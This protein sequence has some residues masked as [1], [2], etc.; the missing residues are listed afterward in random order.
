M[1]LIAIDECHCVS[2]WGHD[3]RPSYS[4]LAKLRDIFPGVPILGLTATATTI[5]AQ[6]IAVNLG[7][8]DPAHFRASFDRKNLYLEVRR[9]ENDDFRA[10]FTPLLTRNLEADSVIAKYTFE[11]STI[12]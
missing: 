1:K 9:R 8:R 6:D 7:M 3:F 5:V 2:N 11:G 4:T 10:I 12:V